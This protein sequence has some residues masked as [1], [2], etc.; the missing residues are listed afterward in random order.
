MIQEFKNVTI[1]Y[2]KIVMVRQEYSDR[3]HRRYKVCLLGGFEIE[4][5]VDEM[6]RAEFIENWTESKFWK[7]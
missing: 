1:D 5:S 3:S 4:I 2:S 7:D 6:S